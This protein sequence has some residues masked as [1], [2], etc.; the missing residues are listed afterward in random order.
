MPN[1]RNTSTLPP[2]SMSNNCASAVKIISATQ[3]KKKLKKKTQMNG[4]H[5]DFVLLVF[6]GIM[7]MYVLPSVCIFR[8]VCLMNT[9]HR[10]RCRKNSL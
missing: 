6:V 3:A 2:I 5:I 9:L 7:A 8:N 1:K 4:K 10:C